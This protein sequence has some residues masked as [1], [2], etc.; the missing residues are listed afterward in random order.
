MA[1]RLI[2]MK[3]A[4]T[5]GKHKRKIIFALAV[6]LLIFSIGAFVGFRYHERLIRASSISLWMSG[7]AHA[8]KG[9]YDYALLCLSQAIAQRSDPPYYQSRAEIYEEKQTPLMALQFYKL[10]LEG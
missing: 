3:V 9:E 10:A 2:E 4:E 6:V 8:E 1:R 7:V 5:W